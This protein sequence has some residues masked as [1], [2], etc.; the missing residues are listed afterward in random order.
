MIFDKNQ[1]IRFPPAGM[2]MMEL[3]KRM[4]ATIIAEEVTMTDRHKRYA[5]CWVDIK[6]KQMLVQCR[7]QLSAH[8]ILELRDDEVLLLPGEV[9]I[10]VGGLVPLT[11]ATV[12]TE[13]PQLGFSLD[14]LLQT[15]PG[16]E[17]RDLAGL[18]LL[19]LHHDGLAGLLAGLGQHSHRLLV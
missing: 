2:E 6:A 16:R 14:G 4:Y 7:V 19:H 3:L 9:I 12:I 1:R 11:G 15:G 13:V 10:S 18:P 8:L 5:V 17:G